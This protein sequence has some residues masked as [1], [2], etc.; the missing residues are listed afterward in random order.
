MLLSASSIVCMSTCP[1]N[2]LRVFRTDEDALIREIVTLASEYG[3]YGYR[4]IT[5]LLRDR[6]WHV[7]KDRLQR[8]WRREGLKVPEK[9]RPRDRLWLNDG[10][11]LS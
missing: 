8:I 7:G 2:E 3:W 4:R 11:S 10:S 1:P 9:Q 5:A 6:G